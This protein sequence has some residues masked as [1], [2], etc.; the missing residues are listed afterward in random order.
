MFRVFAIS[1]MI[2]VARDIFKTIIPVVYFLRWPKFPSAKASAVISTMNLKDFV[3]VLNGRISNESRILTDPQD[4]EFRVS[5][6]R[7]SNFD[8]KVPG[9]IIKPVSEADVVLT[10]SI[11]SVVFLAMNCWTLDLQA[12]MV[13]NDRLEKQ[14]MLQYRL[15]PLLAVTVHGLL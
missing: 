4:A 5:L 2:V 1:V 8:L 15:S 6:E 11:I 9:A 12:H 7:W 10:V 14:S 13:L 3:E